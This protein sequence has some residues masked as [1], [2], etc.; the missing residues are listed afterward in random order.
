MKQLHG[1]IYGHY[2][3]TLCGSSQILMKIKPM[4]EYLGIGLDHK[5]LKNIRKAAGIERYESVM[6]ENGLL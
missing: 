3:A 2:K 5:T 6:R 1:I 4:W